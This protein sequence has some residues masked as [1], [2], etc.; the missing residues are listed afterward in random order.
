MQNETKSVALAL[1]ALFAVYLPSALWLKNSYEPPRGPPGAVQQLSYF[2]KFGGADGYAFL[3]LAQRLR[4]ASDTENEPNRSPVVLYENGEP[5][6][7]A[8]TLHED[9]SKLGVG[10]FSHWGMQFVFSASDNSDPR[11]NGR[12]YWAVIP[13]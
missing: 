8:H 12:K 11:T 9:I 1:G 13:R 6:G 2:R 10:R 5:L 4:Q 3:A 7:P